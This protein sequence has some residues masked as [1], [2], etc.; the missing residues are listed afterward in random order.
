MI[1]SITTR[2]ELN[3]DFLEEDVAKMI[4]E[5]DYGFFFFFDDIEQ[6]NGTEIVDYKIIN[7]ERNTSS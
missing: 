1:I 4:Q 3:E 5:L 7:N 6:I 2:I